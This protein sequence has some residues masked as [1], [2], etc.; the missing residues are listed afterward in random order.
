MSAD[1][2][3]D[4]YEGLLETNA[5]DIKSG[6]GQYFTPRPLIQAIV[7]CIQPAAGRGRSCDPACGTGGFLLAAHDYLAHHHELDRDQK[8]HLRYD[9]LR[10]VE[11]VDGVARLCAMNLFLHG[12]GPDDDEHGAADQDRR[13][14][15]QRARA[16]TVDV[17]LTNPPFGKKSSHHRRQRGGRDRPGDAHLQ[18]ARLLDDDLEQAAQLRPARQEPAQDPRPRRRRR[19]RQRALRGRRRRDR[20][21]QAPA[22]VRRP[23]AAAAARPAS[24]TPRASRR[25]SSSSTASPAAR[26]RGPRQVWVYDLRTNKHFTLKDEAA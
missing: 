5:Q 25:T 24:S 2:K 18:P 17:V 22:R 8:K 1:V 9:A 6:A 16:T 21:P 15:A 13:R 12:I 19:A 20:A 23:H 3:G 26:S 4:A 10:G 14:P 11:L 7:D